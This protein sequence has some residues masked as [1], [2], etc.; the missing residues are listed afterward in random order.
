MSSTINEPVAARTSFGAF[1]FMVTGEIG[2]A[3][4]TYDHEV[5][6]P[7]ISTKFIETHL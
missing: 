4:A 2:S 5:L 1:V 3:V 7:N 6:P